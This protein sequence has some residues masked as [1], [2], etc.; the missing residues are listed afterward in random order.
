V[1]FQAKQWV[2]CRKANSW[3][4]IAKI[5]TAILANEINGWY[6]LIRNTLQGGE[7]PVFA[8]ATPRQGVEGFFVFL[9]QIIRVHPRSSAVKVLRLLCFFRLRRTTARQV[10]AKKISVISEIRSF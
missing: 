9:R 7:E 3:A 4:I 10:A 8:K 5:G 1:F 6:F 2:F